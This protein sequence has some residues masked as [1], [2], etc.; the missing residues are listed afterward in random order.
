MYVILPV[1]LDCSFLIVP[2]VFFDVYLPVSL[3]CSFLIVPSVLSNVYLPVSL[4]CSFLIVPSVFSNVYLYTTRNIA[5]ITNILKM[6]I[7][8]F[9]YL[10]F[11]TEN[12]YVVGTIYA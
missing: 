4:D 7:K 1:S 9:N 8:R 6:I 2:S 5:Y 12:P 3:D 10:F 11:F